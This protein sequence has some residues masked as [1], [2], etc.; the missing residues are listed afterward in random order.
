VPFLKWR[1]YIKFLPA[2]LLPTF[3]TEAE[4]ELLT[5][6]S[7][8]SAVNAKLKSLT[9]EFEHFRESTQ[10]IDWCNT[11]WWSNGLVTVDDW[12]HLDAMYRSRALEFP[13]IGDAMVPCIDMAN[14]AS[15]DATTALYESDSEG[16]ALLLLREG[17]S[18]EVGEE[19]TITYVYRYMMH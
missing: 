4:Q 5:G 14:H 18:A 7:L 9:R 17:K 16:N 13:G 11:Y 8:K 15:G 2:E 3:W 6:T 19:V 1:R 10:N 12:K